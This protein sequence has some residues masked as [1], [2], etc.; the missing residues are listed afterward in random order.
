MPSELVLD[1]GSTS[2]V[3]I[4]HAS[5]FWYEREP[6]PDVKDQVP[7][8]KLGKEK[9]IA[10]GFPGGRIEKQSTIFPRSVEVE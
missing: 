10:D 6:F 1:E 5:P 9:S 3:K 8:R 4:S 2:E 7:A